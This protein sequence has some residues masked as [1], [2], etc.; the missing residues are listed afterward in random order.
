[1][2]RALVGSEGTCANVVSATLNL[3]ASPPF[4]V[5]TVLGFN[6]P[7]LAADAVPRALEHEPIG[8]EGFDG[9]LVDFMRRKGLA[10]RRSRAA[11]A[12]RRL[13]AGRD[14][15]MVRRRSPGQSRI[16]RPRARNLA[17]RRPLPTS[18]RPPKPPRLA[19]PR[20]RA[21]RHGLRPRRARPLG[22]LGRR[23]R[24][25]R[26][27]G[28]YLRAITAL[29]AEYGYRSP[30]YGHYGQGCVHMRINFD[31]RTEEGLRHFREFIE[32]AADLVLASADRSA[33]STAT[34]SRAP[35]CCPKCLARS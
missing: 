13:S 1:M 4:R 28:N 30:L 25:S 33:A 2:A 31:F 14:G 17:R 20:I 7:F 26:A 9:M 23:R 3:T 12:R 21:G 32:R 27:L 29:M 6:D 22:R 11:P 18:A 24:S 34:A 5:L 16:R 19:R 35:P 10:L 15:R 8:L